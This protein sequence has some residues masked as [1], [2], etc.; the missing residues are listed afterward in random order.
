MNIAIV[1]DEVHWRNIVKA[2]VE[3]IYDSKD[4]CIDIF[5]NGKTYLM[6]K[7]QYAISFIDI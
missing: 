1:D 7:K 4:I 5:E 3:K 6:S 2:E